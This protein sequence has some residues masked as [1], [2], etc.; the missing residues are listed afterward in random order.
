MREQTL[1]LV[2]AFAS[3]AVFASAALAALPDPGMPVE[4]GAPRWS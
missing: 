2:G 1:A 3:V 4:R